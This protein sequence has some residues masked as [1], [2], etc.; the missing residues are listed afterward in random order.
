MLLAIL[1]HPTPLKLSVGGPVASAPTETQGVSLH[2]VHFQEP[3]P[4]CTTVSQCRLKV[5]LSSHDITVKEKHSTYISRTGEHQRA[6]FHACPICL[7]SL[8]PSTIRSMPFWRQGS[9]THKSADLNCL[10]QHS[11]R[12]HHFP[13]APV[14]KPSKTKKMKKKT[15]KHKNNRQTPTH[16]QKKKDQATD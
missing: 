16:T 2:L 14:P 4:C 12:Q 8:L 10:P 1:L 9:S 6:H 13:E 15:Q 3:C 5:S 7:S 11:V